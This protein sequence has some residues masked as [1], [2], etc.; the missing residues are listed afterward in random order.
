MAF[1]TERWA[2]NAGDS[3]ENTTKRERAAL[4]IDMQG[5]YMKAIDWLYDRRG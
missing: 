1:L 5:E 4:T 3:T 2:A